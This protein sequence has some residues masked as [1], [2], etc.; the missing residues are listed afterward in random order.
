MQRVNNMNVTRISRVAFKDRLPFISNSVSFK[1]SSHFHFAYPYTFI[2]AY[3][4]Q[5]KVEEGKI[6]IGKLGE[7]EFEREKEKGGKRESRR[8]IGRGKSRG[9]N[10][11]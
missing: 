9:E 6:G 8:K 11:E 2:H 1:N 4:I 7:R 5:Y 3:G 10:D